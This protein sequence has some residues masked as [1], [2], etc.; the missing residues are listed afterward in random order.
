MGKFVISI[1]KNQEYYFNLRAGNA[2]I[3]GTSEM[4]KALASAKKG[5]ASVQANAP[6]AQ[7][8]DQTAEEVQAQKN[9]KFEIFQDKG[10]KFRFNLKAKNGQVVLASQ[11]YADLKSCMNGIN[12][13]KKNADSPIEGPEK[14]E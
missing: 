12:S 6:I 5:I 4:Y 8:E 9:P 1:S 7:I 11:G 2:Q 3:I 13:V 10:G 14:A